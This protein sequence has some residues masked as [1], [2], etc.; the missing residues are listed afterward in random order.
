[1]DRVYVFCFLVLLAYQSL[2]C[3]ADDEL[4]ASLICKERT[5]PRRETLRYFR[6]ADE[7]GVTCYNPEEIVDLKECIGYCKS[8]GRFTFDNQPTTD[9]WCCV[10]TANT[11][12]K[13]LFECRNGHTET[14]D[15]LIPTKCD[16]M[17][18]SNNSGSPVIPIPT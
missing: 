14:R 18:C 11:T 15:V 8:N 7:R 16:C 10:P 1:M 9:C 17:S 4:A 5:V 6:F 2:L 3:S 12:I 13:V